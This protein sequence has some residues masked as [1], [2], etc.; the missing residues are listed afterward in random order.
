MSEVKVIW[1]FYCMTP[2]PLHVI[3]RKKG[4]RRVL[5]W[6]SIRDSIARLTKRPHITKKSWDKVKSPLYY[7]DI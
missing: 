6:V 3:W 4:R 5:I 1:G 7:L 2:P